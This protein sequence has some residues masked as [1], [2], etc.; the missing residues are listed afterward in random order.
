VSLLLDRDGY[1]A[2]SPSRLGVL[3]CPRRG[4][5][6]LQELDERP[7]TNAV[8]GRAG[9]LVIA[10]LAR[11][12][13]PEDAFDVLPEV[14]DQA[15]TREGLR[16]IAPPADYYRER[17][18]LV[19]ALR[20][21]IVAWPLPLTPSALV[22]VQAR[23]EDRLGQLRVVGR[24]DRLTPPAEPG[25][26]ARVD[27]WKLGIFRDDEVEIPLAVIA[28]AVL[29]RARLSLHCPVTVRWMYVR[30]LTETVWSFDHHTLR[31]EFLRVRAVA[32]NILADRWPPVPGER[33]FHC[34]V[35]TCEYFVGAPDA[36][37]LGLVEDAAE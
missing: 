4:H 32:A 6:Y 11:R 25:D 21:F 30:A 17:S 5:W 22:E 24:L 31:E 13:W 27:D 12:G 26:E 16:F 10:T 29:A 2:L 7:N 23:L 33:C 28:Q 9:H 36:S 14:V 8:V 18:S 35:T 19:E 15:L 34:P 37:N 3:E 1:V 20:R